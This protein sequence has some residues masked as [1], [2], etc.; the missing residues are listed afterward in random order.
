MSQHCS[1]LQRVWSVIPTFKIPGH[2]SKWDLS[3]FAWLGA[4]YPS[5]A[6]NVDELMLLSKGPNG[7][8]E[9]IWAGHDPIDLKK[10]EKCVKGVI[11]CESVKR[12]ADDD[13]ADYQW[14]FR[15]IAVKNVRNLILAVK[16]MKVKE[17]NDIL[18][19]QAN[20][21]TDMFE[22]LETIHIPP[23]WSA[24]KKTQPNLVK[25]PE[26]QYIGMKALW[27]SY[28]KQEG[29][30]HAV[31]VKTIFPKIMPLFTAE[32]ERLVA[33]RKKPTPPLDEEEDE[34]DFRESVDKLQIAV[35]A[36]IASPWTNPFATYRD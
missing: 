3:P 12:K 21:L 17:V 27:I 28:L 5:N 13:D 33:I 14:M 36:M 19:K 22:D 18:I 34:K 1:Y 9:N 11:G 23:R 16:Y 35:D 4:M 31:K 29:A 8:K 6:E 2:F 25:E 24:Y 26:Y 32:V 20:R 7:R 15:K 30:A 10:L